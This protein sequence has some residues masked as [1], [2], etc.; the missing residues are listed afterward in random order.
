[1]KNNTEHIFEI[2][3]ESSS[4]AIMNSP[5]F[6]LSAFDFP[7]PSIPTNLSVTFEGT[8]T[9]R[10]SWTTSSGTKL[11]IIRYRIYRNSAAITTTPTILENVTSHTITYSPSDMVA[12]PWTIRAYNVYNQYSNP[13]SILNITNPSF[14]L[15][16]GTYIPD[17]TRQFQF[18]YT[19]SNFN[20][21][22]TINCVSLTTISNSTSTN[23]TIITNSLSNTSTQTN[24]TV[25]VQDTLGFI[26][27]VEKIITVSNPSIN[28]FGSF[29]YSGTSLTYY[30]TVSVSNPNGSWSITSGN[31]DSISGSNLYYTFSAN[32]T[33]GPKY[34]SVTIT[35]SYGYTANQTADVVL[36]VSFTGN[37]TNVSVTISGTTISFTD[38]ELTLSSY[39]WYLDDSPIS[40]ETS[41]SFIM[42]ASH[43][44]SIYCK[45][46]QTNGQ[47]FTRIIESVRTTNTLPTIFGGS[48][49]GF[50][51]STSPPTP[52]Y[53]A[54]PSTGISL[55]S[56]LMTPAQFSGEGTYTLSGT[57]QNEY[58]I[59]RE[60]YINSFEVHAPTPPSITSAT[61]ISYNSM[62][63]EYSLGDNGTPA[64]IP[65]NITLFYGTVSDIYNHSLTLSHA[66]SSITVESL[67][68]EKITIILD[69]MIMIICI[70]TQKYV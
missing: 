56:I 23:G 49:T 29:F 41:S 69:M 9:Y 52:T 67:V 64:V 63:I 36:S 38:I 31:Y 37:A 68:A 42:T 3:S 7:V 17:S 14:S 35:D 16:N 58:G 48:F 21:R 19:I 44:G 24:F 30:V 13:S 5:S 70:L 4:F 25:T 18:N 66:N 12:Q 65:E 11:S 27:T 61:G 46:T 28:S 8:N 2:Q 53:T 60:I 15:Q 59:E 20:T 45:A 22:Y 40:G 55:V 10:F 33:G 34:V 32:D 26:I 39:Q 51:M 54:I 43:F 62:T 57:Y 47:G 6:T 1:M 50:D